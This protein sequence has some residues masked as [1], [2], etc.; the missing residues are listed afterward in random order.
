[1][2]KPNEL[3][4]PP[5]GHSYSGS[6]S[7]HLPPVPFSNY[8]DYNECTPCY[9]LGPVDRDVKSFVLSAAMKSKISMWFYHGTACDGGIIEGFKGS[10]ARNTTNS[11]LRAAGS[12]QAC[13]GDLAPVHII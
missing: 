2:H 1:M 4:E 6:A 10:V 8:I 12:F 11:K 5:F 9:T 3:T 13:R 7:L